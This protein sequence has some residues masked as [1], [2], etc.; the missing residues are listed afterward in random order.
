[1]FVMERPN[2]EQREKPET[3]TIHVANTMMTNDSMPY[4]VISAYPGIEIAQKYDFVILRNPLE[5]GI[6]RQR[7]LTSSDEYNVGEYTLTKVAKPALTK[8]EPQ[9]HESLIYCNGGFLGALQ[10]HSPNCK[11]NAMNMTGNCGYATPEKC[12]F[13]PHFYKGTVIRKSG[14]TESSY[15]NIMSGKLTGNERSA[16]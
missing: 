2:S 4:V 1:M 9:C 6:Q 10:K 11:S 15:V 12:L 14:F 16:T 3:A 5:G 8:R 7:S 13:S